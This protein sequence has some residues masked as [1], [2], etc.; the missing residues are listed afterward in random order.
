[1]EQHHQ[2]GGFAVG[3]REAGTGEQCH[4]WKNA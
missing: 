4:G 1:M 3:G 2:F